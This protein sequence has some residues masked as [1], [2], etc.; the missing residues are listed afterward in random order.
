MGSSAHFD[1]VEYLAVQTD[2]TFIIKTSSSSSPTFHHGEQMSSYQSKSP[3]QLISYSVSCF[4]GIYFQ[5]PAAIWILFFSFHC[6]FARWV[7]CLN[8]PFQQTFSRQ[9]HVSRAFKIVNKMHNNTS[10]QNYLKYS[11][12]Q[13][14]SCF[15]HSKIVVCSR[16]SALLAF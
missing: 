14:L 11:V 8:V 13:V 15:Y 9:P 12:C 6:I 1:P 4:G 3:L 16:L 5:T 2:S 7:F 10:E